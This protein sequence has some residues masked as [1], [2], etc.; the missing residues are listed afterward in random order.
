MPLSHLGEL[1][2]QKSSWVERCIRMLGKV[3]RRCATTR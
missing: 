2:L 3:L 1:A